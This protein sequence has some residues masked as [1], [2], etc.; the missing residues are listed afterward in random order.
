MSDG[1]A[2]LA[3]RLRRD[4]SL[5]TPN[6]KRAA[7]RLLADFPMAGLDSAA[8]FGEAAGVSAPTVLRM[9]AKLGFSSYGAFQDE[10][11]SELAAR[12]ATPLTKGLQRFADDPLAAFAAACGR[13][14]A[15]H[16]RQC[17]ARRVQGG[18]GAP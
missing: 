13:Q 8:R 15:R 2:S 3:E 18:G 14:S 7:Q 17:A 5:M 9:I 4:L 1:G 11:K 6:E 12:R 10:L 16:G